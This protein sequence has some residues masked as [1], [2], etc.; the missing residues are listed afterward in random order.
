MTELDEADDPRSVTIDTVEGTFP[1]TV[2]RT[3]ERIDDD[4][5][6]VS[7]HVRG[8]PSG[9]MGVLSPLM[10]PMVRRSVDGD[11]SRLKELLEG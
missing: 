7:A 4:R 10:R 2:T 5:S 6:T 8:S 1:I 3:V 11:Y 9:L